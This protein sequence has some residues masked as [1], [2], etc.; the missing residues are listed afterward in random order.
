MKVISP[1]Y[2]IEIKRS[3]YSFISFSEPRGHSYTPSKQINSEIFYVDFGP[4]INFSKQQHSKTISS[5]LFIL[6]C[7]CRWHLPFLRLL[8]E[9]GAFNEMGQT[10]TFCQVLGALMN[11]LFYIL[12][13]PTQI[14]FWLFSAAQQTTSKIQ[15]ENSNSL[16][17]SLLLFVMI[18]QVHSVPLLLQCQL[19]CTDSLTC[20]EVD[21][22]YNQEL[23]YGTAGRLNSPHRP[24]PTNASAPHSMVVR[25]L[26]RAF[27]ETKAKTEVF[28]IHSNENATMLLLLHFYQKQAED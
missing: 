23:S 2:E 18:L 28:L 25:I 24:F 14:T 10:V 15:T 9:R 4:Q 11:C 21:A 3:F 6:K 17:L 12:S 13:I 7:N 20:L 27:Q 22:G 26:K 16:L 19:G 5:L 1:G 8:Y